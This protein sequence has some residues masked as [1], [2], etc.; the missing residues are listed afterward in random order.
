[1]NVIVK[2]LF[3]WVIRCLSNVCNFKPSSN[4]GF[5]YFDNANNNSFQK[6]ICNIFIYIYIITIWRTRKENLRIG[7]L[8]N[9]IIRKLIDYRKLIK[10]IYNQKFEKLF[11][12]RSVHDINI[13]ID[14]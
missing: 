11:E 4:I 5:L 12:E 3:L 8:K 14:L 2:P 13:L 6:N 10:L 7:D 1:M 9:M